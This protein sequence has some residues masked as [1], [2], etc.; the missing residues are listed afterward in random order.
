[1][2]FI[3]YY[4]PKLF[5]NKQIKQINSILKKGEPF[6][7]GANTKKTSTCFSSPYKNIKNIIPEF[8]DRISIINRDSFGFVIDRFFNEDHFIMNI[9]DHKD[10]AEYNWH[11]DGT[12]FESNFTTKLTVL[13]NLS[14]K[15]YE[16]GEFSLFT[17]SGAEVIKQ[18]EEPGSIIVFPPFVPHRV[19]PVTKGQRISGTFFVSGPWWR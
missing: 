5:D 4:I 1:M 19:S 11:T 6:D 3:Y 7:K 8:E 9:Y 13:I 14:E 12:T 2:K 18:F 10:K 15:K 16:G 17:G